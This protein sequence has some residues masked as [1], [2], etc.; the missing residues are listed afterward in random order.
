MR[1]VWDVKNFVLGL[2]IGT[3]VGLAVTGVLFV[4]WLIVIAAIRSHLLGPDY[5]VLP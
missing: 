4:L 3:S 5:P 2:V 1:W